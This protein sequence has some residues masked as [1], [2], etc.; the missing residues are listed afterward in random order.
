MCLTLSP[1]QTSFAFLESVDCMFQE[2][3]L[4]GG[5]ASLMPNTNHSQFCCVQMKSCNLLFH[6]LCTHSGLVH[7]V[8][9]YLLSPL[10]SSFIEPGN[11]KLNF[12]APYRWPCDVVPA[13]KTYVEVFWRSHPFLTK[14][15]KFQEEKTLHL[16]PT[17]LFLQAVIRM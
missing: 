2:M 4:F 17:F 12:P 8:P 10:P 6:I 3:K 16:L 5:L 11:L 14:K 15:T 9:N 7:S 1:G 13:N